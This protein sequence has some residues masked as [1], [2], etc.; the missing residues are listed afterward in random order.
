MPGLRCRL[1]VQRPAFTLVELLVVIAI[2]GI[3]VS[4]L[5]P[6]VQAAR[7]AARRMQCSNNLK[8]L[9]LALHN[10]HEVHK[11][12]PPNSPWS[13]TGAHR[14]GS[15]LLKLMPF[16]EQG[17]FYDQIDFKGDVH[18]QIEADAR[19]YANKFSFLTCPSDTHKGLGGSGKAVT[20]YGPSCGAQKTFSNGNSCGAPYDGNTFGTGASADANSSDPTQISGLF[21]RSG[22][23]ARIADIRDGTSN[24]I[25]MG[26]VRPGCSSGQWIL[27]WYSS[28]NWYVGTAPPINF[29]TCPSEPPGKESGSMDCNHWGNWNT[30]AGFKSTHQGGA[31]FVLA[32]G[33]V[34][35]ISENIDYRNFQRL[36][37][38]RDGEVLLPF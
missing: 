7:E 28:Q 15:I 36:G 27:G 1:R 35:F 25:A 24:T 31:N 34:R 14:K 32:D 9:G 23:A 22:F 2:I 33:A 3:L 12:F 4:L 20:N 6:A 21:S 16:I 38:R 18:A 37:C 17:A 8:Q 29:P 30:P 11:R 10:Y 26:E 5:L 13:G 19:L